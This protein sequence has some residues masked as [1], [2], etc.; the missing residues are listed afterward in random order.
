MRGE[1]AQFAVEKMQVAEQAYALL[2]GRLARV[3]R[4]FT[5][6]R[7]ALQR[8]GAQLAPELRGAP[9]TVY[10]L[11]S[12]SAAADGAAAALAAEAPAAAAGGGGG[13]SS[14]IYGRQQRAAQTRAQRSGTIQIR[15]Q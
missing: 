5:D 4:N 11:A 10:G 7:S 1:A 9:L 8:E 13:G 2:R 12:G 3:H 6:Y 14:A 15:Y